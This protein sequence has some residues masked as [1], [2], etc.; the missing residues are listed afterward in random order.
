M[1]EPPL[2]P[3]SNR[4]VYADVLFN[5]FGIPALYVSNT[6]SLAIFGSGA[7][8]GVVVELGYDVSTS[9]AVCDGDIIPTS[10]RRLN[11]GGAELDERLAG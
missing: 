9:V 4:E 3:L 2:S 11:L 10:L 6:S 8:T 5:D 1:T 7:V